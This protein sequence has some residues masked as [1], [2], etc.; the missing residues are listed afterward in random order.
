MAK[1]RLDVITR[2][3]RS[4]GVVA[5]DETPDSGIAAEAGSVLDALFAEIE[6]A[7][8]VAWDLTTVPDEAFIPL[9]NLLAA[10]IAPTFQVG[11]VFSRPVSWMRLMSVIRPNDMED[12]RDIDESGT[13]DTSEAM[14]QDQY[15]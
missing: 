13:V 6:T 3:L 7:K 15:Y 14:A 2:A 10:E 8:A 5:H 11:T 9:A 1:T 4:V 12:A